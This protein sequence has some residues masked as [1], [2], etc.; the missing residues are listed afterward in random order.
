M[1]ITSS[2]PKVSKTPPTILPSI[3]PKSRQNKSLR[4]S[5]SN[6]CTDAS[7]DEGLKEN[8]QKIQMKNI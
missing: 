3:H 2:K 8:D 1:K 4:I 6:E 7:R 5:P